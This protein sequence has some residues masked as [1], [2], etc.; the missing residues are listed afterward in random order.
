MFP[1]HQIIFT[2]L[3]LCLCGEFASLT[4]RSVWDVL[5]IT[6]F[7]HLKFPNWIFGHCMLQEKH[8]IEMSSLLPR[9][10]IRRS[11]PQFALFDKPFFRQVLAFNS[12]LHKV[13][14]QKETITF[15]GRP[16]CCCRITSCAVLWRV[17]DFSI[18]NSFGFSHQQQAC[19]SLSKL[20]P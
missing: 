5:C 13:S 18:I 1:S 15:I 3:F 16:L 20:A 19:S 7:P 17:R 10:S 2:R 12:L 4:R 8:T 9:S 6:S 14:F 11:S